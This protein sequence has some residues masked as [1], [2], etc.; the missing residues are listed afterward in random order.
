M[1]NN[2]GF[3]LVELMVTI[4]VLAIIASF[5]IPAFGDMLEKQNLKKS[6]E[7]L[8]VVMNKARSKAVLE[9]RPQVKVNLAPSA[10]A[11]DTEEELNWRP[12][13]K[14]VLK[15]GSPT[16]IQFGITGGVFIPD[17]DH[18]S[19]VSPAT[20]DTIFTICSTNIGTNKKSK[21]ITVSRMGTIQIIT[22]GAC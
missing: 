17:S 11:V 14:S 1:R 19:S 5:A 20:A 16:T 4:A 18:P 2:R 22:E 9:R 10:D 6:T 3:T 8:I 15:I 21:T 12:S 7:E 13:G